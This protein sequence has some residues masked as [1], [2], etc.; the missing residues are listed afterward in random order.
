MII[1]V[2]YVY[3]LRVKLIVVICEQN[4]RDKIKIWPMFKY[5]VT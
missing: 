4:L 2:Y 1:N 3:W 5:S